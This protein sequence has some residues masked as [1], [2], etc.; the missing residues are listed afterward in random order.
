MR[1]QHPTL[2]HHSC[3]FTMH[4]VV[5]APSIEGTSIQGRLWASAG[6]I[7]H[8]DGSRALAKL[9][10]GRRSHCS[11]VSQLS[12]YHLR[13]IHTIH[14]VVLIYDI[15][16]V[17]IYIMFISFSSIPYPLSLP[18]PSSFPPI[19]LTLTM[20]SLRSQESSHTV[21]H[22]PE[23]STSTRPLLAVNPPTRRREAAGCT[24]S[25]WGGVKRQGEG[26]YCKWQAT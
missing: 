10:I 19:I 15:S 3:I 1:T 25:D 12:A 17:F 2:A 5:D 8:P 16:A 26:D 11:I 13:S 4:T 23:Y 9:C 24:K 18:Y 14:C 21:P 6:H 22:S 7:V 20:A